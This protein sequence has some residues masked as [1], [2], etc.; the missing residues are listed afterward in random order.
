MRKRVLD[1][2]RDRWTRGT[3]GKKALHRSGVR[4]RYRGDEEDL[5]Q[6]VHVVEVDLAL[7]AAVREGHSTIA[8]SW[9][10]QNSYSTGFSGFAD[11]EAVETRTCVAGVGS[12][13]LLRFS[14]LSSWLS[15]RS[16]Y[17]SASRFQVSGVRKDPSIPNHPTRF[18]LIPQPRA[19]SR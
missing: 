15:V 19:P 9:M 7:G 4:V 14:V 5:L 12:S 8:A 17:P 11:T 10:R 13:W 3:A 2:G 16:L 6:V 1:A 18:P